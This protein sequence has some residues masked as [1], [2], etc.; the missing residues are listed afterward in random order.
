VFLVVGQ[1]PA[2]SAAVAEALDAH[3]GLLVAGSGELIVPLAFV[4]ERVREPE[5]ARRL[6]AGLVI[7]SREFPDGI[8][9]H[10]DADGV[11]AALEG[12]PVRLGA[13]LTAL[14]DAVAAAAGVRS[15]GT[16]LP[17]MGMAVLTRTGLHEAGIPYL[18]VV[19]DIRTMVAAGLGGGE[20]PAIAARRWDTQNRMFRE[21]WGTDPTRYRTV[22]YEDLR[23]DPA[24]TVRDLGRFLGADGTPSAVPL[25][26]EEAVAP[27]DAATRAI[28]TAEAA[29]GLYDFGYDPP[30]GSPRRVLRA[31][32]RRGEAAIAKG[33]RGLAAATDRAWVLRAPAPGRPSR[34]DDDLAKAWC[35]VCRWSGEAFSGVPHAES[36]DCPRCGTIAR[37]RFHLHG[38]GREPAIAG[39]RVL[40]TAP[41][42]AGQYARA[43]GHWYDYAVLDPSP[44]SGPLGHLGDIADLPAAAADCILSAHDLQTVPDPEAVLDQ[45]ARV[46]APGGLLLLQVPVL[47][48][49]TEA[50]EVADTAAPGTAR[51]S[52]G[53]D[54]HERVTAAGF[55]TDV[56]VTEELADL[57]GADP[58]TWAKAPGSG[59][60]DVESLLAALGDVA[61]SVVADRRTARRAGWLPPVL[62][63]TVRGRLSTGAT[64]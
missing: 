16:V 5:A 33:R 30:A 52:F 17:R 8:G 23:A 4:L 9:R 42:S 50:L 15:A 1:R 40:E 48:G 64:P 6:F 41:R 63:V 3:P 10:L 47:S 58:S 53:A 28:V 22:R 29:E 43:M 7:A 59:E 13:L 18:H 46:L 37:Q 11:R 21:R 62:F 51:W 27:L 55:T 24:G 35:N 32:S 20:G 54:V 2:G 19:R 61:L 38:L 56:L 39:R 14:Y 36:A 44:A 45:F 49:S 34:R 12:V 60:V 57:V 31:V 25:P 26:A